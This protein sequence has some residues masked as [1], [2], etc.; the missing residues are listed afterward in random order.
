MFKSINIFKQLRRTDYWIRPNS[1]LCSDVCGVSV[2]ILRGRGLG[3][4][5]TGG[6]GAVEESQPEEETHVCYDCAERRQ[7]RAEWAW[8]ADPSSVA[9]ACQ[10][11]YL[12]TAVCLNNSFFLIDRG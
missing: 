12:R 4:H 3:Q 9:V 5:D 6:K 7:H 10:L 8:R 11:T 1:A 2:Y